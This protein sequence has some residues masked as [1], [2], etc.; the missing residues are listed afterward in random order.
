[1]PTRDVNQEAL[2]QVRE[3]T[4]D[5]EPSHGRRT[6]CLSRTS[7]FSPPERSFELQAAAGKP[8]WTIPISSEPPRPRPV[9]VCDEVITLNLYRIAQEAVANALSTAN[10][11]R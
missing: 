9:R 1:M 10:P 4:D 5:C 2:G 8:L 7:Y 11:A 3:A 6:P